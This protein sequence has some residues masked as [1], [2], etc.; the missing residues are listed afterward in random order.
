MK[1]NKKLNVNFFQIIYISLPLP[2][3]IQV[4]YW[5][6][7][8]FPGKNS[9]FYFVL[10]ILTTLIIL[11]LFFLYKHVESGGVGQ[12]KSTEI[13][14]IYVI[15]VAGAISLG[16]ILFLP[17]YL[18]QPLKGHDIV[19]YG[20]EGKIYYRDKSLQTKYTMVDPESGYV[21]FS[22]HSPHFPLI[23]TLEKMSH[24]MLGVSHGDTFFK[25]ITPV[26]WL[27]IV[28]GGGLLFHKKDLRYSAIV[29]LAFFSS[30]LF[31]LK[32]MQYH[33]DMYRM[34]YMTASIIMLYY[35]VKMDTRFYIILLG[36]LCGA[37]A[38]IHSIGTITSVI[39]IG[40]YFIFSA[41]PLKKRIMN[42]CILGTITFF[43]GGGHY[44]INY[45]HGN[46]WLFT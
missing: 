17:G 35:A 12:N 33:I 37:S 39:I 40:T 13:K 18:S 31:L 29:L 30:H 22:R 34:Y 7:Y 9:S 41:R 25:L 36:F 46:R 32:P 2:I 8:C 6:L 45:L 23:L 4:L 10:S 14:P 44:I 21:M 19:V 38:A 26:Y 27:L 3:A 24:D 20:N 1:N 5:L 11:L 42:A 15:I 16:S 43:L 28:F